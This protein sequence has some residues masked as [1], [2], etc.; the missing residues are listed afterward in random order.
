MI[1]YLDTSALAKRYL[2]ESGTQ[3]VLQWISQA[4][5]TCTSLI[6]RAEMGAA[7]TKAVRMAWMS[8]EQGQS[9]L[10]QFRSEW[11]MF[12]RL[13]IHESTVQRADELACRYGLRGFVS[14]HLACAILYCESLGAP[15]TF[16]T[17]DRSLW[18]AAR[19]EGLYVLP[20]DFP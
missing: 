1:L 16:A 3:D 7:I 12:G 11:E 15:V 9:V 17:Y 6:T 18:Q 8:V 2:A 20:T 14:V 5:L 19:V 10:Q 13:P 4:R